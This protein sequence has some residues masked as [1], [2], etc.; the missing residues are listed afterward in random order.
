LASTLIVFSSAGLASEKDDASSSK[1]L[2][3][4]LIEGASETATY[5][6]D[7]R[8]VKI[9]YTQPVTRPLVIK[10]GHH[11]IEV[12]EGE[13]VALRAEVVLTPGETKTLRV[14]RAEP[15]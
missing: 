9:P 8:A 3:S 2:A 15:E 1:G 7:G 5:Y 11:V 13:D 14:K 4:I 6:I 10:A 12:H